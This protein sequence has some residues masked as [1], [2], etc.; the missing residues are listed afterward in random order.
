VS[1]RDCLVA[2][3]LVASAWP[4][5][6]ESEAQS[7]DVPASMTRPVYPRAKKVDVVDT[8][9]G[10]RVADEYRWLENAEDPDTTRWVDAQNAMFRRWVDGPTRDAI[11][12]RLSSLVDYPRT[13][14][15]VRRGSRYFF[16]HNTGLQ[17]Q[18]VEYWSEGLAAEWHVLV[19]PNAL[20]SDGTAALTGLFVNDSGTLAAYAISRS[21]SDRQ[22]IR[23]RDVTTG[24][25]L[26]DR[27]LWAKF[28]SL[29]W[30]KD[31]SGFYYT[32]F[33]EPGTV[34]PGE[35][36]YG[37]M[38]CFH[39]LGDPQEKDT[40]VFTHPSDKQVVF[41]V[42]L[43]LDDRYLA[44]T[45]MQGASDKSELYVVDRHAAHPVPVQVFSGFADSWLFIDATAGSLFLVTDRD[46]P[47]R[48]VMALT[49]PEAL[50]PPGTNGHPVPPG[51]PAIE[52]ATLREVVPQSTERLDSA[53]VVNGQVVACYLRDANSQVRLFGLDGVAR[54]RV[55]LPTI[56]TVGTLSGEPG[57]QELFLSFTSFITPAAPYRYD[58][59]TRKLQTWGR[60]GSPGV[61]PL[62]YDARQV[63][64][65]SKDGTRVSMFIVQPHG[66]PLDGDR[67]VLL[68]GYGGFDIS[69]TPEFTPARFA[70][71][72]R[73]GVL[74]VA[75]LRGGGEYGEAWH[76]AGM[77]ERK[78]NVFDDF[79]AAAEWLIANKYTR[80]GRLAVQGGSNG[81]LLTGAVLTQ[82]PDLFGAVLCHVPVADMLRYHRFTVGRF[83]IPEYG[84]SE[85]PAQFKVLLQYSPLHNVK[86]G[87][88]YPPTLITTAD[89]D[90]RVAPG[91]AKKFAARLQAATDGP[92]PILI[93]V[94]AKAGHGAGKPIGKV[95][96]EQADIYAFLVKAL[97][98]E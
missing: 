13:G 46:A 8:Y 21:G 3:A 44:I 9:H 71:L 49:L 61:D 42:A 48:R 22:E 68:Y 57:D 5:A 2:L 14:V 18:P 58:F 19:D 41:D 79:V 52:G 54:G 39:A 78:Q 90:D 80:P 35:E 95:I 70:W 97:R 45:A 87:T 6:A 27:I 91:M 40:V 15:P 4:L 20:S 92:G 60:T 56:G 74:A 62:K 55:T 50:K 26:A 84:S 81:G 38:V 96:D 72:E 82:R 37:S 89:T 11:H 28:A 32:R 93:R 1:V 94:E 98:V 25:D 29:E 51:S 69:L 77:L 83:W 36:N 30:L 59:T 16:S 73:G 63:W 31:G 10:T 17:N 67:P 76:E 7:V 85:D 64:Y 47:M 66:L 43:A 65:T 23:V 75:N 86:D 12:T 88:A 33:P 34:P 53:A 24:R